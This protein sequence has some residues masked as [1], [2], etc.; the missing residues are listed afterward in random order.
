[1]DDFELKDAIDQ[2]YLRKYQYEVIKID[3]SIPE[4]FLTKYGM[5]ATF[6]EAIQK[7]YTL[8]TQYAINNVHK[9]INHNDT[10]RLLVYT[11]PTKII[12][13]NLVQSLEETKPWHSVEKI[14][15]FTSDENNRTREQLLREFRSGLT[16]ILVAI[17]CLDEGVNLPIAD[18]A[19]MIESSESD[20]RQWVQRRGR[21]L[22]KVDGESKV[23][24][25]IDF[26][27]SF[28]GP[29][30]TNGE[31]G[32]KLREKRELSFSRIQEFSKTAELKSRLKLRKQ[33]GA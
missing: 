26:H 31:I 3:V 25:I 22:R 30:L 28:T 15:K 27:P 16:K 20:D 18:T 29:A 23:A 5:Q 7:F 33:W 1:M 2:G 32:R 21:I 6:N 4:Q 9:I 12:A 13:E 24:K 10:D 8:A 17:K 19:L 11:G 14:K